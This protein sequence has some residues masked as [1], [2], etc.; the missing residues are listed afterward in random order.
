[1]QPIGQRTWAIA[2]GWIPDSS[3]GPEPAMTSHEAACL[4]NCG[5]EDANVEIVV[6]LAVPI[7]AHTRP[8][9]RQAANALLSTIAFAAG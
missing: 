1:M 4:L 5:D 3:N 7:D 2:E 8:D 6:F 9:S